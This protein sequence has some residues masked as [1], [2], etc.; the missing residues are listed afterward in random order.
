MT[1]MLW[2]VARLIGSVL[3]VVL[4]QHHRLARRLLGEIEVAHADGRVDLS[5]FVISAV[6]VS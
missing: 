1:A 3:F 2:T 5:F 6:L 4:E